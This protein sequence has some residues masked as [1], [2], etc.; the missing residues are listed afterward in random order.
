MLLL[1]ILE[2]VPQKLNYVLIGDEIP[3]VV[4]SLFRVDVSIVTVNFIFLT[5]FD[6]LERRS[7][8]DLQLVHFSYLVM[9]KVCVSGLR[10]QY[11]LYARL[12]LKLQ[13]INSLLQYYSYLFAFLGCSLGGVSVFF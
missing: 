7:V 10:R 12:F 2:A 13:L 4:V 5:V 6:F 9:L 1:V 11:I 8:L 3:D